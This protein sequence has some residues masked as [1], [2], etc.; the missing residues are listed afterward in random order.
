MCVPCKVEVANC[1]GGYI[2]VWLPDEYSKTTNA[3][4]NTK[5]TDETMKH[6]GDNELHSETVR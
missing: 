3:N 2:F 5:I 4:I 6:L 1:T